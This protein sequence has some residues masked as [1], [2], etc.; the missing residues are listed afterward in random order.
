MAIQV[1]AEMLANTHAVFGLQKKA[2]LQVLQYPLSVTGLTV[3]AQ[4]RNHVIA[5]INSETTVHTKLL[6]L[7]LPMN[8]E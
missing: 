6:F 8:Y 7:F 5:P 1:V 4:R 2:I 3:V